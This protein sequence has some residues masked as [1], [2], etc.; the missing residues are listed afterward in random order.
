MGGNIIGHFSF[1]FDCNY[2]HKGRKCR[3]EIVENESKK[4]IQPEREMTSDLSK[5]LCTLGGNHRLNFS[6][7]VLGILTVVTK[8]AL[9]FK[10]KKNIIEIE[11]VVPC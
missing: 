6:T 4:I 5:L 10:K 3:E 9:S 11:N 7:N 2:K 8:D 1:C